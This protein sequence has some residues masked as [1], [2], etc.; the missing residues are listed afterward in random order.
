MTGAKTSWKYK[1]SQ[2]FITF[3]HPNNLSPCS[4]IIAQHHSC[5]H[6]DIQLWLFVKSWDYSYWCDPTGTLLEYTLFT[7]TTAEVK[8]KIS[9]SSNCTNYHDLLTGDWFKL[10]DL[11]VSVWLFNH[12]IEME[13]LSD[14]EYVDSCSNLTTKQCSQ[15][16]RVVCCLCVHLC[17]VSEQVPIMVV[18]HKFV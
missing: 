17:E 12:V 6:C 7:L 9:C 5:W 14:I 11:L 10:L 8:C 2:P 1:V 18:L 13:K 4:W 3:Y 16:I 15:N